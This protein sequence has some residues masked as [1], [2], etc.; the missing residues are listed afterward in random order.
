[1]GKFQSSIKVFKFHNLHGWHRI[2]AYD[3]NY[4][5]F[6]R[7]F[8]TIKVLATCG[9]LFV[10][11]YYWLCFKVEWWSRKCKMTRSNTHACKIMTKNIIPRGMV[12]SPVFVVNHS[13]YFAGTLSGNSTTRF[14]LWFWLKFKI[15]YRNFSL[16]HFICSL[17]RSVAVFLNYMNLFHYN[18]LWYQRIVLQNQNWFDLCF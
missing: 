9:I 2:I 10:A 5:N 1:M 18:R 15:L 7:I 14:K 12:R 8:L 6:Y 3:N 11:Y 16:M 4:N 13:R 17:F